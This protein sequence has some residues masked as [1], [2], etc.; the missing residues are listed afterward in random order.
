MTVPQGGVGLFT[1]ASQLRAW[2]RDAWAS[3]GA[4]R[5]T[6]WGLAQ[7]PAGRN[8]EADTGVGTPGGG[9]G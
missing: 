5:L 4:C 8:E 1:A 6:V 3:S 9:C 7:P 2:L